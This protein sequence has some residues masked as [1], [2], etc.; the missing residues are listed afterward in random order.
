MLQCIVNA[1][2]AVLL[3]AD[4]TGGTDHGGGAQREGGGG[5]EQPAEELS[6]AEAPA[7]VWATRVRQF[8]VQEGPRLLVALA[9][10]D[11]VEEDW[12]E[13]VREEVRETLSDTPYR[14]AS[15]V[16]VSS[17]GVMEGRAGK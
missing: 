12:L 10:S 1:V 9:K 13:L 6:K 5:D 3:R 17:V 4:H 2:D 14:S 11:L 8:L 7:E 15:I 16:P